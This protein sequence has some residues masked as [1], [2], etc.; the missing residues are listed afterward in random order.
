MCQNVYPHR[1]SPNVFMILR[2]KHR[3]I[4]VNEHLILLIKHLICW[5]KRAIS[6]FLGSV[7]R[8]VKRSGRGNLGTSQTCGRRDCGNC[9][10]EVTGCCAALRCA[11]LPCA[12]LSLFF[13]IMYLSP[14]LH[15]C[16]IGSS[17]LIFFPLYLINST[18]LVHTSSCFFFVHTASLHPYLTFSLFESLCS[19]LF[20]LSAHF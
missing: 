6:E 15:I 10:I 13:L 17:P 8:G 19:Y 2:W 9:S 4:C 3:L 7:T 12:S 5:P 20:L 18:N 11:L 1:V 14:S 16:I